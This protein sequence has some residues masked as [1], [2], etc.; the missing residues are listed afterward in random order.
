MADPRRRQQVEHAVENAVA[1]PQNRDE[2]DLLASKHRHP[3]RFERRFDLGLFE[4]QVAGCLIGEEQ[5]DLAQQR[6]EFR[7]AGLAFAHQR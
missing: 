2:A 4:C 1:G 5:A 3:R 6:A 7:G